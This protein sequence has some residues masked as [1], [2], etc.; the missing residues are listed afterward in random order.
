MIDVSCAIIRN[1]ESEIL[2][3]RRGENTDHPLKWEFP[4][5]KIK[6]GETAE[7]SIIREIDE[8]LSMDIIITDD[9][10]EVEYDYGIKQVRLFPLVCDTLSDEPVLTEHISYKWIGNDELKDVDLCEADIIVAGNYMDWCRRDQKSKNNRQEIPGVID[11]DTGEKLKEMLLEKGGYF[12][13]DIIADT[14]IERPEVLNLM[15]QYS[16]SDDKQL[17]FRA[18]YCIVKAE[19][20]APGIAEPYY[21][22]FTRFLHSLE[23]ESAIR[24]FLKILNSYNIEKLAEDDQGYLADNCFRYLNTGRYPPAI[25]AYSMDA[26]YKLSLIYP[27]L[28]NELRSSILRVMEDGSAGVKARGNQILQQLNPD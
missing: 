13:V 6:R 10:P 16:L 15:V 7:D 22:K 27:S 25:L 12:A 3:V 26:L 21:G 2:V 9:L 24:S 23:N 18:S 11:I 14:I 1:D 20:K 5:G 19:E 17:A 28:T 4:G 8:E